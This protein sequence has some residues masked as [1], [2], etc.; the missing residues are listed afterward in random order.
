VDEQPPLPG[1]PDAGV[2]V[3][4]SI[5]TETLVLTESVV[6]VMV[7]DPVPELVVTVT[8]SVVEEVFE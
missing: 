2:M 3:K 1:A 8:V 5:A 6:S 7:D 4:D